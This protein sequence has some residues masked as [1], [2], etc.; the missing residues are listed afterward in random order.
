MNKGGDSNSSKDDAS[1]VSL[2]M[3]DISAPPDESTEA[4]PSDE[5]KKS[6]G[7]ILHPSQPSECDKSQAFAKVP[8]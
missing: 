8:L 6:Y 2:H 1:K 7:A 4:A 5:E 3:T